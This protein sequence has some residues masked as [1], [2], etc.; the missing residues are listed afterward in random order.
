MRIRQLGFGLFCSVLML[1]TFL[2]VALAADSGVTE[3]AADKP[4]P[5]IGLVLS[6][7]GA[8]G[9]AHVGVLKV[10]EEL[11]IPIDYIAG[12]SMG[13]IVGGL[14]A[15]G[16]TAE[17][18]QQIVAEADW[19]RLLSDRTPRALRSFRRKSDEVGFLVDFDMGIDESGLI[20]P[21]GLVQ[22]Q[23]LEIEL[24]R[25]TLPVVSIDDFDKLPIP[26]RAIATDIVNGEAVVLD[27]GDLAT[28]MRASMSAPGIF[29][30]VKSNGRLLVD[31]GIANNLPIQ[32]VHEMGADILI[33]VDVGFPLLS[34]SQLNSALGITKQ[35]LT[36]LINARAKE[37]IALLTPGDI[38]ISPE[39]DDLG[40]EAFQRMREAHRLGRA[41]ALE[42]TV[43]LARYS[44]PSDVYLA[45]RRDIERIR[46]GPP[47]IDRI[48]VKNESRLSPKVIAERLGSHK[49]NPLDLDQLESDISDIY[50]L[51]TFET[52]TYDITN[53]SG[54]TSLALQATEK[55]WGPNYL[56]FGINLE[57]DFE[58]E[59][60]YN[61]AARFT[62]TE[63]NEKGGEF[64]A[65]IQIG[66]SPRLFA[67]LYQPLDYASRWFIN[68]LFVYQRENSTLF[69]D[70][71]QIA[72]FLSTSTTFSFEGG[73]QLGNWGEIRIGLSRSRV[74]DA[75]KVGQPDLRNESTDIYGLSAGFSYD[76]IDRVAIP[77][78]GMNLSLGWSS[79]RESLGSDIAFDIAGLFFLKP[80][81]WGD[82]TLLHWW[83]IE[84]TTRDET[85]GVK[86]LSLGGLFNLSGYAAG[87]LLG[88]HS[89]IG[90]LLYYRRLGKRAMPLLSTPIYL[91][92]SIEI[93]NVWQSRSEISANNTLLAGSI[94]IVFDTLLGPLY[95]AYA[96]AEDNHQSAY[97]FLGQTF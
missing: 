21:G 57:D 6:G 22:G 91:G 14:Y 70:G 45:Y 8:R 15:S 39:L 37:Q 79:I 4:R 32:V 68:P 54:E 35:M 10:L 41:K 19:G 59:S 1:S 67:E 63:I 36:I 75:L 55:S 40:S 97:L 78:S 62:R 17:A 81:T 64:R 87:E 42:L 73:R 50:G 71:L 88:K 24:K 34:E 77:R 52:V 95:L 93:G 56:R 92:G 84:G 18:L 83:D 90:R 29:K 46:Q 23:N 12:T 31:G 2:R 85:A 96:R 53:E 76:T 44:V 66:E 3:R 58:G 30:P 48:M 69:Q 33:V 94:F 47:R 49:G 9:A 38:L 13:A 7:G 60:H 27:S 51:D 20:F 11:R 25:Q 61:F 82:H 80:Q 28:A 43:D 89:A 86:P 5:T 26:F 16:M 65:E 74:D 72:E